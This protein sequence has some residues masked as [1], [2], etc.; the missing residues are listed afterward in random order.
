M[1]PS[2]IASIAEV[3]WAVFELSARGLSSLEITLEEVNE[4]EALSDPLKDAHVSGEPPTTCL[5]YRERVQVTPEQY[6]AVVAPPVEDRSELGQRAMHR[7]IAPF[8]E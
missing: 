7:S 5:C 1:G 4:T 2:V 8:V 3:A 6:V